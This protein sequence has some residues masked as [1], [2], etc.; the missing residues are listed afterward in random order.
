[1]HQR[2]KCAQI[3]CI[4]TEPMLRV[5]ESKAGCVNKTAQQKWGLHPLKNSTC[6][7]LNRNVKAEFLKTD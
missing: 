5:S 4:C 1:M 3:Q 7:N 2:G 6:R